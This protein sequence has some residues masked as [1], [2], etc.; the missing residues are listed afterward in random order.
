MVDVHS[1]PFGFGLLSA[2]E[3]AAVPV[4]DGAGGRL[5]GLD[6]VESLDG[7][8]GIASRRTRAEDALARLGQVAGAR[9]DDHRHVPGAGGPQAEHAEVRVDSSLGHGSAGV[10]SQIEGCRG[11]EPGRALAQRDDLLGPLTQQVLE[12]D[13][14]HE[15]HRPAAIGPGVVPLHG[16]MVQRK[17]PLAGEPVHHPVGAL[18]DPAGLRISCVRCS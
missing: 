14:L 4:E 2:G 6:G 9:S 10:E 5:A 13:G 12:P 1:P 7:G 17:R 16:H 3:V 11:V 18:D 15:L 8:I